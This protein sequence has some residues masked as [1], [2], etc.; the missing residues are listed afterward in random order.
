[1][2]EVLDRVDP[3]RAWAALVAGVVAIL[4]VGSVLFPRRLYANFIWH[5]FWGPVYADSEGASCVAWANGERRLLGGSECASLK[6]DPE[7]LSELGPVA[8][9]GYTVVSEI[10]YVVIL[11]VMLIGVIFLLRRLDLERYRS[12][13]YALF[14]FML[15]GGAL[16][17]VED[18]NVAA[19]RAG[20]GQPISY[21]LNTLLISPLIYFTMFFIALGALVV[22]VWLER[23]DYVDR[24]EYPLAGIGTAALVA[25]VGYLAALA[26]TTD[27]VYFY[28]AIPAVVLVGATAAAAATWLAVERYVP[29]VNRG[30]GLIGLV[31][32]WGHAIDGVANVVG[33][34]WAAE[35]GVHYGDLGPK[36]PVNAGIVDLT[37][38]VLPASI[39]HYTGTAW[40]FLLVK[41]VAAVLVVWVFDDEIFEES[42]RYTTLLLITVLAV[43][44]GP[45]TRDMLRATFGI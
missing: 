12:L 38:A 33:L 25:C 24:Y 16:R 39:T 44:L 26:A 23:G 13:F 7:R 3:E 40:P 5:Y 31:V 2:D 36:H 45:G 35:L 17:V 6:N 30:T 8:E 28:P 21:P 42:P 22:A 27:Y 20:V 10:G 9:P 43:G 37:A 29:E 32:I 18:A 19:I 41:L 11:L 1:M 34:D 14:P 15:F 4:G